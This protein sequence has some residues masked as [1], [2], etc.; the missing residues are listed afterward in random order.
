MSLTE[1]DLYLP[2]GEQM[3]CQ[4]I[5]GGTGNLEKI[6]SSLNV[7]QIAS[8]LLLQ[9]LSEMKNKP[10]IHPERFLAERINVLNSRIKRDGLPSMKAEVV[11][12]LNFK[13]IEEGYKLL[14]SFKI[15]LLDEE[16]IRDQNYLTFEAKWDYTFNEKYREK[17]K[18]SLVSVNDHITGKIQTLTE[19]QS[20]I[21]REIEAQTD[22]HIH[23]QGYAGTGKS[24][25]I[26]N[27]I[28]M[29]DRKGVQIL[30]LAERQKQIEALV[31]GIGQMNHVFTKTFASLAYDIIPQDLTNRTNRNMRN[32]SSSRATM[33]DDEVIRHFGILPS[34][35]LSPHFIARASRGT[36]FGFCHSEDYII[37]LS[38]IPNWCVSSLDETTKQVVLHYAAELWEEIINP[39]SKN[40]K[41]HIRGYHRIKWAALNGWQIPRRYTHIL[42]DE[43]HDLAKPMLQILDRSTQAVISLGDEYQNLQG[44]SQQRSHIIRHREVTHSVRSGRSIENIVNPIIDIH[45][46]K[47]KVPFHGDP[48]NNLEITYYN[49]PQVPDKPVT[50][51]VSGMW[52]LFEWAQR[53]ASKDFN[54]ILLSD[55]K[56]LNMFVND[57]IELYHRDIQ[58]RHGKLFRFKDWDEVTRHHH[59]NQSFQNID[60]L[61]SKGYGYKDW[62]KTSAKFTQSNSNSYLLGMVEDVRNHEFQAVMIT[63][64]VI[65]PVWQAKP[66]NIG[67]VGSAIYVAVTRAKQCLIVPEELRNWI[68]EIAVS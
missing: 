57:C 65:S 6:I 53:V 22:D 62:E 67:A 40:F 42:I 14:S 38:H 32:I 55:I 17:F 39:T 66:E 47:T 45:P 44:S 1:V 56:N 52:G 41:P 49:K 58:P 24:S 3:L 50:I 8:L 20:R 31:S 35:K 7:P 30:I 48:L 9:K 51:L 60:T 21:Y 4:I 61:L 26:K 28:S 11:L 18:R 19:E 10:S 68:E 16:A 13:N 27:L 15:A 59:D 43:C 25:L 12:V 36:L 29:L 34:G 46:G 2:I 54:L 23:V 5:D 33:S 64:E 37:Q 63:P